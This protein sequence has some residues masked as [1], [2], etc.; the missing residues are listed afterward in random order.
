M[1]E[2]ATVLFIAVF[3]IIVWVH[4]DPKLQDAIISRIHA[5][6]CQILPPPAFPGESWIGG[7]KQ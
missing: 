3:A 2:L 7:E 1:E 6:A 5:P 4:N